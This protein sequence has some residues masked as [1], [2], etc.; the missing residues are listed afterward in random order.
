MKILLADDEPIVR[1]GLKQMIKNLNFSFAAVLEAATGGEAI[2]L[3]GRY[4]LFYV[5]FWFCFTEQSLR[6]LQHPI[7]G[8]F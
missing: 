3:T 7:T 8:Q 6:D 2:A 5:F 1:R 4:R